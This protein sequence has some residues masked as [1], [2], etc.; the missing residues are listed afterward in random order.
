MDNGKSINNSW[1]G[2]PKI[3]IIFSKTIFYGKDKLKILIKKFKN[4]KI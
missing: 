2:G 4:K 1:G 3:L